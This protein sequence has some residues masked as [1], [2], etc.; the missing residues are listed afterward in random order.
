MRHPDVP[1]LGKGEA[2]NDISAMTIIVVRIAFLVMCTLAGY[3]VSQVNPDMISSAWEGTAIGFGFGGLLIAFDEML[4]GFSL[5]AFSATTF[6]ML[7]GMLMAWIVLQSGLFVYTADSV[8]WLIRLGLFTGFSYIGIILAMRSNKEDFYLVIPFVRFAPQHK[9]ENPLVLDTSAIVDG[10]IAELIDRG[11]LEGIVVVPHFVLKELQEIADSKDFLRRGRGRR[12]LEMLGRIQ[13]NSRL[14]VKIHPADFPEENGVDLKLVRLARMLGA[15]LVTTD[16][17]LA[18]MAELQTVRCLNLHEL[19]GCLKP[20]VL[21]GEVYNLKIV[22][23]GR[24]KDQGVA[25]LNDGTM[26]VVNSGRSLIGKNVNVQIISM[27]QTGAGIIVFAD[28]QQ[29]A[30]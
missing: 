28:P 30:A 4:K 17:N 29:E 19:A 23:E 8:Q 11:I 12:G 7:L 13:K 15:K 3:A 5:R 22:R 2:Q 6:G 18:K 26:V 9:P 1:L 16:Y 27:L 20:V 21:P 24:E 10:R 14:E 25:Y